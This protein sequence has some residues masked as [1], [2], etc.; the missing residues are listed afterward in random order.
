M[1]HLDRACAW[2][3][4]RRQGAPESRLE[5][6]A[7]R[8][9]RVQPRYQGRSQRDPRG[10]GGTC[11]CVHDRDCHGLAPPLLVAHP[12]TPSG[13]FQR[14]LPCTAVTVVVTHT[15]KCVQGPLGGAAGDNVASIPS[16][17]RRAAAEFRPARCVPG[18]R[19]RR[20]RGA[21][22]TCPSVPGNRG[23]AATVWLRGETAQPGSGDALTACWRAGSRC[24]AWQAEWRATGILK[25][26]A[27]SHPSATIDLSSRQP[28]PHAV[29][30]THTRSLS[31]PQAPQLTAPERWRG[32]DACKAPMRRRTRP[33]VPSSSRLRS[34]ACPLLP[35]APPAVP[36]FP[37]F[38]A[39]CAHP[40]IGRCEIAA[41]APMVL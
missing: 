38:V 23:A 22:L 14:P 21:C 8:Q 35:T 26:P 2:D 33:C 16:G 30:H 31:L 29:P 37:T 17:G 4:H 27:A 5:H 32:W 25:S 6:G 40:G 18:A 41:R 28:S 15:G 9:N 13:P 3:A 39:D 36:T 24:R 19:P 11:L 34:C 10:G 20:A 1:Q 7:G 12:E